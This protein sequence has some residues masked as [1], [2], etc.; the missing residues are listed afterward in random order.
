MNDTAKGSST[1]LGETVMTSFYSYR[2]TFATSLAAVSVMLGEVRS[3]GGPQ[4]YADADPNVKLLREKCG[5]GPIVAVG[6]AQNPRS[7]EIV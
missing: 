2:H 7:D 6:G 3:G 5:G 1:P 4:G